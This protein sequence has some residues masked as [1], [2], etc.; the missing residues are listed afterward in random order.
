MSFK[1][2]EVITNKGLIKHYNE[3]QNFFTLEKLINIGGD[4]DPKVYEETVGIINLFPSLTQE[5]YSRY[6]IE[7]GDIAAN[8]A[9]IFKIL[10]SIGNLITIFPYEFHFYQCIIN[11]IFKYKNLDAETTI[12]DENFIKNNMFIDDKNIKSKFYEDMI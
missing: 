12:K 6:Y 2:I 11:N 9:G 7:I 3:H 1:N 5:T 8:V 10:F 4:V